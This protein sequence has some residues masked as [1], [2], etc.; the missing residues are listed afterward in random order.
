MTSRLTTLCAAAAA[1][2][3]VVSCGGDDDSSADGEST[4]PD[5]LVDVMVE[6]GAPAELAE[7]I[8]GKLD[9]VTV[10]ALVDFLESVAA[11]DEV[12][13]TEGVAEQMINSQAACAAEG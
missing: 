2:T 1:L 7:C 12:I 13:A 8:A 5:A 4:S 3:L 10:N 11:G 6:D 9:G